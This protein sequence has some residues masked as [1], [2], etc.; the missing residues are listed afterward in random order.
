MFI[1][2]SGYGESVSVLFG[3]VD[4][5]NYFEGC[6]KTLSKPHQLPLSHLT[7]SN[8]LLISFIKD[9]TAVCSLSLRQIHSIQS[10]VSSKFHIC[11]QLPYNHLT[12]PFRSVLRLPPQF[13]IARGLHSLFPS[14]KKNSHLLLFPVVYFY[15]C[16]YERY[17]VS[18]LLQGTRIVAWF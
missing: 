17:T 11:H 16:L 9:C 7:D 14:G 13:C 18:R 2:K 4:P 3:E 1:R 8:S 6:A 5:Q 10:L 15:E 12:T